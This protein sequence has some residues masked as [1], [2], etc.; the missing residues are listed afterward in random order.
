MSCM[1]IFVPKKETLYSMNNNDLQLIL[2]TNVSLVVIE[3]YDEPRALDLLKG[4]FQINNIP[5][6][7]WTV[8]EGLETLGF[9]VKLM[10]HE[11]RTDP[12]ELLMHI[13]SSRQASA[14]VLCDF[15]PYLEEHKTIRHLKDI[16]LESNRTG[17]KIVLISH[18]LKLPPELSRY[19]SSV[20]L[21]L[22]D[23]SEILSIVRSQARSW[24]EAN[25]K[26]RIKTDNVTLN[27][28]VN[29]L[30]GLTHQDVERLAHSAIADDGAI[31][32]SDLPE[33]TRAKFE[34]MDMEGV[35]HY[36]Y[37]LAH[38]KDVGGLNGL[39]GWLAERKD[40]VLEPVCIDEPFL[41]APKGVLL[42]GVQGGGKS[43]AAKAI[44]GIWGLP[45]L[46]LDMASLFNKFIG[47]TEKNLRKS[48]E[49]ADLMAPCVLWMDEI[50]K[51]LAN[52]SSDNATGK[53]LLGTLLT[54]IAERKSRV[55]MVAT[56]N[57]ISIL[58][59]ELMRKGRFDEV[60][61]V[62]LPDNETREIIFRIHMEKRKINPESFDLTVLAQQTEGF[63]GAE[64]E[65]AI[66]SGI[67]SARAQKENVNQV[68]VSRAI[69]NTQP[70]SVVMS[71]KI[72]RLRSWAIKR[73]VAAN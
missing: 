16:A 25:K 55:F 23:E 21:S 68:H 72:E 7:R 67:Y 2:N 54:W 48:L 13:K 65:Q 40:A 60:F 37:S 52:D 4:A 66:V 36:E 43:L 63:T 69:L 58:P 34:L 27:K 10:E 53:R 9:G 19:A 57:D 1:L 49:L 62:D 35:L 47:E 41:D 24:A 73:A 32:E 45:L 6:W 38:L 30:S 11:K 70:L 26:S 71:E 33:I 46:R 61:F 39:K 59:P 3:T 29:N 50:E 14:F 20:R 5:A 42:F 56:S 64:I 22:P 44:A 28:L 31:T 15:H 17:H 51:G 18:E 8:T 12:D